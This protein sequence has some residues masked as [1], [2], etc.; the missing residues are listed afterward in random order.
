MPGFC[1]Y[2]F[3]ACLYPVPAA[4]VERGM[5]CY[6][7]V[8]PGFRVYMFGSSPYPVPAAEV[9]RGMSCIVL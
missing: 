4:E 5:S 3:G 1:V 2:M 9:E 7:K 8:M 6:I